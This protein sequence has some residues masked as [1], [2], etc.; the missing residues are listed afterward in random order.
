MERVNYL[1]KLEITSLKCEKD[2]LITSLD[3]IDILILK[4]QKDS[5]CTQLSNPQKK[6]RTE[7]TE[8]DIKRRG[9]KRENEET[10]P[11]AHLHPSHKIDL[12]E[13]AVRGLLVYYN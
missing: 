5:Q 11:K 8:S 9:V 3:E 4:K 10:T 1:I 2:F 7:T 13:K 6:V 12:T